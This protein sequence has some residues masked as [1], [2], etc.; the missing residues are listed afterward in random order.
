M[1]KNDYTIMAVIKALRT[2]KQF[3]PDRRAMTLTELSRACD[4]TKSSM[5]RI[6]ESL[7]AEDFV[8]YDEETKKYKLG[9]A[10]FCLGNTAFDFLDIKK[11]A[12]PL[13]KCAA[14]ESQLL[15]HLA[16]LEDSD[17]VVIDKIWPTNSMDMLVMLSY[18]GGVV[19]VHCTGVGKVLAAYAGEQ[20]QR[21]LIAKCDF[22]V[23][24]EK[25]IS[26][27]EDLLKELHLVKQKG[28][29][30]NDGEHE[31]YLRC[32]TRPVYNGEGKVIAAF[33]LSGLKDVITNER[34]DYYNEIS[35][36][37]ALEVSKVF[38]YHQMG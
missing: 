27:K 17:V 13:L 16:V 10:I 2:L 14:A 15:I 20:E 12:G 8:R 29:A 19:P 36:K 34:F 28:M 37:T 22:E 31:S 11:T 4:I 23:Y 35:R 9:I 38:G 1:A 18:I 24:T 26:N 25:T 30:F 33:S 3:T 5:L 7:E 6:M 32:I 21:E